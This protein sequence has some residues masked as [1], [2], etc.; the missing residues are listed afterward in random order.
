MFRL[1]H[2]AIEF[3]HVS[4]TYPG[5]KTS[6]PSSSPSSSSSSSALKK[7][8]SLNLQMEREKQKE[9][10]DALLHPRDTGVD[11]DEEKKK[12]KEKMCH[13]HEQPAMEREG[14]T[15]EDKKKERAHSSS[16]PLYLLDDVSFK[17][18]PGEKVAFVGSSGV[19]KST[20][21]KLLYRMYDPLQGV[22]RIDGQNVRELDLHSFRKHIGVVPQDMALFNDT[23]EFNLKY[24][25]PTATREQVVEASKQAEIYDMIMSLPR[26]FDT[27]VGERGMKLSGGER[28][29]IG[30]ARCLLRNP[31]IA[32]F[33][34]ATSALDS[35]TEQKILKAFQAMSRGRT[36]I[37]IAHRLSTI[38]HAD[39]IFYLKD[40]K[41]AERGKHEELL[42]KPEGLYRRLWR[43]QQQRHSLRPH[44]SDGK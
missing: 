36:T 30:I 23:V 39:Q 16:S 12:K 21:I 43:S 20:L 4:F 1:H 33:D 34:E 37:V 14:E 2:G 3:D 31:A 35:H 42:A 7:E 6:S 40:G 15:G 24:G 13:A 11:M 29:R 9:T 18:G 38:M 26:Q 27:V 10:S 8:E 32:I 25:S 41:V 22:I 5:E 44:D 17:I 28:Q 19:G